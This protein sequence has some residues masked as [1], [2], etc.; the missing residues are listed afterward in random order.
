MP[1]STTMAIN[2]VMIPGWPISWHELS[3]HSVGVQAHKVAL[4]HFQAVQQQPPGDDGVE[5]H[6]QIVARDAK[7]AVPVPLGSLGLQHVEGAGDA[8][9][10][11]PAHGQL[12]DH[13]RQAQDHQEQQIDEHKGPAAILTGDIG[14][15]PHISQP[16]GTACRDQQK[17]HPGGKGLSLLHKKINISSSDSRGP[18]SSLQYGPRCRYILHDFSSLVNHFLH[19]CSVSALF[20]RKTGRCPRFGRDSALALFSQEFSGSANRS[21]QD[22][23]STSGISSSPTTWSIR[24]SWRASSGVKRFW[25]RFIT[26]RIYW[27]LML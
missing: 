18:S 17:A 1:M 27:L 10:A 12:H 2:R 6:Q 20:C 14:E 26:W 21:P 7:P 8:P 13:H 4:G 24:S 16:D 11:P 15:P 23:R 19:F 9:L 22:F 3:G 25:I 5:H